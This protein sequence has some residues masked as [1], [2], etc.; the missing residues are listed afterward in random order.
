MAKKNALEKELFDS[1]SATNSLSNDICGIKAN[2]ES[3]YER[4]LKKLIKDTIRKIVNIE[5]NERCCDCGAPEP[6]WLVTNLGVLVCI[7]CCGVH[8]EMGVQISKTQSLKIDRL[9][10]SQLI[11]SQNKNFKLKKRDFRPNLVLKF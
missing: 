11:V 10:S 1:S 4:T 9:A 8:R 7:E 6:D 3:S 5:G 2:E